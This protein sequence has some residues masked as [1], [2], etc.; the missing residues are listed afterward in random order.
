MSN[1]IREALD[2]TLGADKDNDEPSPA[3]LRRGMYTLARET[4]RGLKEVLDEVRGL[5]RDLR[6]IRGLLVTTS[7]GFLGSLVTLVTILISSR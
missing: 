5:R 3:A 6:Y 4:D 7:V 1:Q 2:D